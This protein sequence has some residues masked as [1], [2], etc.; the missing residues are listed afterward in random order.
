MNSKNLNSTNALYSNNIYTTSAAFGTL[1]ST[2]PSATISSLGAIT[3][4]SGK[5]SDLVASGGTELGSVSVYGNNWPPLVSALYCNGGFT[6]DGGLLHGASISCLPVSGI[7]T[8]RFS[9]DPTGISMITPTFLSL[10]GGGYMSFNVGGYMR[11]RCGG[12]FSIDNQNIQIISS[13]LG[14][15]NCQLSV[16]HLLPPSDTGNTY[17]LLIDNGYG[18]G[19][20]LNN[21]N[22]INGTAFNS[23]W[24]GNATT[25]LNM[26]NF[27]ISNVSNIISTSTDLNLQPAGGYTIKL[28]GTVNT[29][30]NLFMNGGYIQ[31]ND[32]PIRIRADSYHVLVFGGG[33]GTYNVGVDG[34]YLVGYGG[35]A[36]GTSGTSFNDKS[37]E[38][39]YNNVY[40][41]KPLDMGYN[42]IT[43]IRNEYFKYGGRITSFVGGYGGQQGILDI[44]YPIAGT[45][46][47]NDGILRL[48]GGQVNGDRVI[49]LDSVNI[50]INVPVGYGSLY[51]NA[52]TNMLNNNITNIK[53]L[54][55]DNGAKLETFVSGG[56]NF[57]DIGAPS[58][59][60]SNV[61]NMRF[62]G[63]GGNMIFDNNIGINANGSNYLYFQNGGASIS[64]ASD[65]NIYL[66]GNGLSGTARYVNF[67]ETNIAMNGPVGNATIFM[68]GNSIRNVG[69]FTRNLSSSVISQPV[70]QYGTDGTGSGVS[71]AVTVTLPTAYSNTNYVVQVTMKDPPTAQ[72]YATPITTTTFKIGWTSAG[73]GTQNIMWTTFGN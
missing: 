45:G 6:V 49:A 54:F 43:N 53:S 8:Q 52:E 1:A 73:T 72:L 35:G 17:P 51:L 11:L 4:L 16:Q 13:T 57:L 58:P 12:D 37:L 46:H 26:N 32:N 67:Q 40:L 22:S 20:I 65:Q 29:Y 70:I 42:D 47:T 2:V 34:P 27:N 36:L 31:M 62:F 38:W 59:I 14:N 66:T 60:G 33:S 44:A 50:S 68:N 24:F 25:D 41:Y 64:I 61:A 71:G 69:D 23:L 55:F 18:A 30:N 7:N 3:G 39:S 56:M 21:I 9:I 48:F 28:N 5:F 15:Q 19:V 10:T 63:A